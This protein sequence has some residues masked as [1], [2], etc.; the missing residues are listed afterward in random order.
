MEPLI[1]VRIALAHSHPN[2]FG[3]GERALLELARGL[4]QRHQVRLLVGRFEPGQT[5]AE[6]ATFPRARLGTLQWLGSRCPDDV[7]VANSFG[8]NLLAL[9]NSSRVVYWVHSVRS[10]FLLPGA[11]RP[12]LR[13]RRVLDWLAVR[14]DARLVANS[15]F[16]A[17]RLRALYRRDPDAVVYPGVDLD[18]FRPASDSGAHG[19]GYALTV[20]RLAPEKGLDRLLQMWRDLPDVP[21][22][23]VGAGH[24]DEVRRLRALAP[25]Q[26]VFRGPLE[27]SALVAA[28]QQAALAVFTPRAEE[29]GLAPL[30]AMA[31]GLTVVAWREGGLAETVLDGDTGYLAADATTLQR[32]VRALA[33]D[34]ELRHALGRAARRRAEQFGWSRTVAEIERICL[35]VAGATV[36]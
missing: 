22:H 28:Y 25:R 33:R 5:Y 2:T 21:L 12:D 32:R 26:V 16:T 1:R 15:R 17:A 23:V 13:L 3:G 24:V 18:V 10:R 14:R 30:E 7:V 31:C 4:A 8:A 20:G 11:R 19:G 6:L 36:G 27:S 29:F 9:R 34:A 35:E